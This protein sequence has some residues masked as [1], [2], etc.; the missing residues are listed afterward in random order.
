MRRTALSYTFSTNPAA[1]TAAML[2]VALAAAAL[3]SW[4]LRLSSP[5]GGRPD[6]SSEEPANESLRSWSRK[7]KRREQP[8]AEG[9]EVAPARERPLAPE[10]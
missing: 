2:G 5:R 9:I 10:G 1:K 8:T 4:L 3:A 7:W 6:E